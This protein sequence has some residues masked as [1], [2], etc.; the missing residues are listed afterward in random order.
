[1]CVFCSWYLNGYRCTDL[2]VSIFFW[3][4]NSPVLYVTLFQSEV[5]LRYYQVALVK[6]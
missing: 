3:F 5:L 2:V 6:S 4:R 1:M